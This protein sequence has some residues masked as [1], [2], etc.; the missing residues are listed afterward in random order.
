MAEYS[1]VSF[2][3]GELAPSLYARVDQARYITGLKTCRNFFVMKH[4]GAA[5]RPGTKYIAATKNASETVRLIPFI[6]NSDQ[7]YVLEF[8]NLYIRFYKDG[9]QLQSGGSPYEI[10]TPYAEADLPNLKYVQSGDTIT[11]VHPSYAPRELVRSADT[12]WSLSTITFASA[13]SAPTLLYQPTGV[14]IDTTKPLIGYKITAVSA[15]GEES[16]ASSTIAPHQT[17]V[18][19]TPI[20][21]GWNSVTDAIFYK[22]YR[23]VTALAG[24]TTYNL[25]G[26]LIGTTSGTLFQDV[27]QTADVEQAPEDQS[28]FSATDDYPGAVTYAQNAL[29]FA[30]SN[31]NPETV[32]KSRIGSYKNFLRKYPLAA[33]DSINFPLLGRKVSRILHLLENDRLLA[34]TSE[35]EWIVRG[36][37]AGVII[38]TAINQ[39]QQTENGSGSLR[40]IV[41]NGTV[42]YLQARGNIVRDFLFDFELESYRGNDLTVFS[43]HLFEDKTIVDWDYQQ[44]PHSIVWAVRSDG[45]LLGLTYIRE[46]SMVAWHR[47]DFENGT[48]EN[49]IV[50]P[51]GDKEYLYLVIKRTIDGSTVR[52]IERFNNRF[53]SEIEDAIFVDSSVTFDGRNT[54][55]SH[56][57]TLSGGSDWDHDETLTLTSSDSYFVSGDV[58]NAIHLTGSDGTI[59]RFLIKGFTSDT[60][61]TGQVDIDVPTV[62]QSVAISDWT[63]AIT[64]LTGLDH[65]EGE[66]VSIIA[67]GFVI[68]S[69]NNED[70]GGATVSGG[71]ITLSRPYG[72][73]HVGLPITADIETLNLTKNGFPSRGNDKNISAVNAFVEQS[74][75]VFAGTKEPAA[76][77]PLAGLH[78]LKVNNQDVTNA[79]V[80][81][82]TGWAEIPT[83]SR[84]NDNGRVFVRQVDPLP[85]KLLALLPEGYIGG[86]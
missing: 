58:G 64:A 12:S 33:D 83:E 44:T 26:G 42:L 17:D 45:T 16:L 60:I 57:M 84:W 21:F 69:V 4:G 7:T 73:I 59:I 52:Y 67:D 40:P 76:S 54:N 25:E 56:T 41:V 20:S 55:T 13:L 62:M 37:D 43:A 27:G 15:T 8:G 32:W 2:A 29:F 11:I 1:Q 74:R 70:Y 36:N 19:S 53:F 65:L 23:F 49:V 28:L 10:S 30:N 79:P 80:A 38:P 86:R 31:N 66:S 72:V 14:V 18:N 78:E 9:S 22:V 3:S 71:A 47:H 51:E 81:L 61:V 75:G 77:T 5:N 82:L 6:F 39:R 63:K 24:S 68:N 46:H 35:S 85:L 34:F 50:V 48:V